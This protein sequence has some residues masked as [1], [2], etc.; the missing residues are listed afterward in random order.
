MNNTYLLYSLTY[1]LLFVMEQFLIDNTALFESLVDKFTAEDVVGKHGSS[2]ASPNPD[3]VVCTRIRPLLEE[4]LSSG[5]RASIFPRTS[6]VGVVDLH[7]LYNSVRGP[8]LRVC[9]QTQPCSSCFSSSSFVAR[10]RS[11]FKMRPLTEYKCNNSL[12][13]S[14]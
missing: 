10:G 12:Q 6:E 3:I 2:S 9:C 11:S 13:S 7:E 4:E 5:F 14:K 8:T 1:D